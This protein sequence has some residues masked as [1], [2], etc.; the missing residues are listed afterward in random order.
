MRVW[1]QLVAAVLILTL[2]PLVSAGG[3]G[4]EEN[5]S[6]SASCRVAVIPACC[7][8]IEHEVVVPAVTRRVCTPIYETK[9]VPVF[10]IRRTPRYRTV[11]KPVYAWRTVPVYEAG[12]TPIWGRQKMLVYR[13]VTSPVLMP[14]L[15][16]FCCDCRVVKVGEQKRCALVDQGSKPAIVGYRQESRA[17]GMRREK[18]VVRTTTE[19][20]IEGYDVERVQVGTREARRLK[21][22]HT[23]LVEIAA[24]SSRVLEQRITLPARRVTVVP[25]DAVEQALLPGTSAVLSEAEYDAAVARAAEQG[26]P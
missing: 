22:Y 6:A 1:Q 15:N 5:A 7:V 19:R 21:G 16:P 25:P 9:T 4:E 20:I 10:E 3:E 26:A 2:A 12:R 11:E 14:V 17:L 8:A 23:K 13:E 24:A 18:Y